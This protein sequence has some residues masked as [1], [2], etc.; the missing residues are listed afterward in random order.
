MM[1]PI[2]NKFQNESYAEGRIE[3]AKITAQN[4]YVAGMSIEKIASA[5]NYS[6]DEVRTWIE[7]KD[8]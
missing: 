5:V 3:Q 2:Q 4:L 8:K 1:S 7:K 6:V